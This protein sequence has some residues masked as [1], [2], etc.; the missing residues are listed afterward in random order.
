MQGL[1]D[2]GLC[3]GIVSYPNS[4]FVSQDTIAERETFVIA[5]IDA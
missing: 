4:P 2:V 5:G 1:K 3:R